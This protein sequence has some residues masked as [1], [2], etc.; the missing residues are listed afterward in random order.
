MWD[1]FL[2][3]MLSVRCL[4]MSCRIRT[5]MG[6][7]CFSAWSWRAFFIR[8]SIFSEI[9]IGFIPPF[10]IVCRYFCQTFSL[11]LDIRCIYIK[12]TTNISQPTSWKAEQWK[13]RTE[14]VTAHLGWPLW[15]VRSAPEEAVTTFM[16]HCIGY[17]ADWWGFFG[18]AA[19]RGGKENPH[20]HRVDGGR[21]KGI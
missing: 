12:Y 3:Q 5:V 13:I 21:A 2:L 18:W 8:G 1:R 17:Y 20:R 14:F 10:Y 16:P 4:S 7:N 6:S 11:T 19:W 9:I 15:L